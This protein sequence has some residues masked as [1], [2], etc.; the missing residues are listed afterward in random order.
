LCGGELSTR[1][2]EILTVV[3]G[4]P[5]TLSETDTVETVAL[6]FVASPFRLMVAGGICVIRQ[7]DNE[8][9]TWAAAEWLAM[10]MPPHWGAALEFCRPQSLGTQKERDSGATMSKSAPNKQVNLRPI[11]RLCVSSAIR[12]F[13]QFMTNDEPTVRIS[14]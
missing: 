10:S 13:R 1:R 8:A 12:F 11:A 4:A 14:L 6:A 5:G 7:Q 9:V 3:T 2:E